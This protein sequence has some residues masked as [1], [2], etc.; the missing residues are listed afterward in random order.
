MPLAMITWLEVPT[1]PQ[2]P[3]G[4]WGPTDPRPGWGL[5]T[6][7]PPLGIWGPTDPRPGW[8]LP[9]SQPRPDNT[10][11][12]N[13]PYPDHGL[14]GNQPYPDQGLPGAQPRPDHGLPPFATNLPVIPPQQ[15]LPDPDDPNKA[16]LVAYMPKSDGSGY[17]RITFTIDLT[18]RPSKPPPT[19]ATPKPA[20]PAQ[21]Q[22][23]SKPI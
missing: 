16:Y 1:T 21:G 18:Q 6:P 17:E 2:P 15:P 7:Q 22:Q 13:Q 9:G 5:P 20:D 10:L 23:R 4:I 3:L 14:P 8:G 19:E 11:P 12:G